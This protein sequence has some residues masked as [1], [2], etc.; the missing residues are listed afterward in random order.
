MDPTLAA[1]TRDQQRG[2]LVLTRSGA[3]TTAT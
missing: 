1:M 3:S 2:G